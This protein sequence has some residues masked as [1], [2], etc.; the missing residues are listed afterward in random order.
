MTKQHS[1]WLCFSQ[2][3][4]AGKFPNSLPS[5]GLLGGEWGGYGN[6]ASGRRAACVYRIVTGDH[7]KDRQRETSVSSSLFSRP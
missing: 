5:K 4:P 3:E 1:A 6:D 2:P 7:I